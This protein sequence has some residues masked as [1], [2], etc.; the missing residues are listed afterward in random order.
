MATFGDISYGLSI[1]AGES[2][3]RNAGNS[4]FEAYTPGT[5]GGGFL[6]LAI[7]DYQG[8]SVIGLLGS[9]TATRTGT[10]GSIRLVSDSLPVGSNCIAELRKNSTASGN[11]LSATLQITTTESATNGQYIG[12]TVSTFSST[13]IAAGDVFYVYLTGVGSTTPASN[14]RALLYTT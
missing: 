4:A 5:G 13:A 10:L 3:R 12:T 8:L 11:V 14:V 7:S 6:E 1:A 9:Y 2:V